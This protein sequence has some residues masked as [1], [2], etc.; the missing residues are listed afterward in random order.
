VVDAAF[1]NNLKAL[2]KGVVHSGDETSGKERVIVDLEKI[3]SDIKV[4]YVM[5]FVFT[6]GCCF[7][8]VPFGVA[9]VTHSANPADILGT[10]NVTAIG[11]F[12]GAFLAK[13]VREDRFFSLVLLNKAVGILDRAPRHFMD[14]SAALHAEIVQH[15]PRAPAKL[16]V[17]FDM[18]KGGVF[19]FGCLGESS[20]KV[21]LGWDVANGQVD[22]DV[23]CV[24]F[25]GQQHVLETVFFGNLES[26]GP[27]SAPG[28]VKHSGDNLTGEGDGDDEIINVDFSRLGPSVCQLFFTINIYTRGRSFQ[29][30]ANPYCRV[31]M[32]RDEVCKY[33]LRETPPNTNGLVICRLFRSHAGGSWSFQ[34]LGLPSRGSMWRDSVP[35]MLRVFNAK[36][37]EL[38]SQE[39]SMPQ[40]SIRRAPSTDGCCVTM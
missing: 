24:L 33:R 2:G 11:G 36:Q 30:V 3:P 38:Y 9:Q 14:C 13:I 23:S 34:A 25:D 27:H 29:Q 26:S 20:A 17:S 37:H 6:E 1:F 40:S 4:I 22:L 31:L 5:C 8:D 35:D 21:C 10:F 16:K 28:A 18:R 39:S 7:S 32:G 19:D 15:I 12:T